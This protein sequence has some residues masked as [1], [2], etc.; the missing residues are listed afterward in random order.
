MDEQNR[1][2]TDN[3]PA[4]K[5]VETDQKPGQVRKPQDEESQE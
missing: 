3:R 1:Q 2:P 5:T 4:D